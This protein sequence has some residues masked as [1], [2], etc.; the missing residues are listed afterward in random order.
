MATYIGQLHGTGIA[1][2]EE[3]CVYLIL[4]S[5]SKRTGSLALYLGSFQVGVFVIVFCC[6]A[7]RSSGWQTNGPLRHSVKRHR[8]I[9][10]RLPASGNTGVKS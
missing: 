7:V 2:V 8:G 10:P 6:Q 4:N 3:A 5:Y 1:V 9:S